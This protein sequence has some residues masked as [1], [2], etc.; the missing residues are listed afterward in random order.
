MTMS[1]HIEVAWWNA[2]HYIWQVVTVTDCSYIITL[3]NMW[4]P[5]YTLWQIS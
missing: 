3:S 2:S 5:F 4:N 1:L